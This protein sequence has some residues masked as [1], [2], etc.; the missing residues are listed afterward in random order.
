MPPE[1]APGTGVWGQSSHVPT[2]FWAYA[3]QVAA[4]REYSLPR[5]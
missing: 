4:P 5:G 2:T 3:E 1:M